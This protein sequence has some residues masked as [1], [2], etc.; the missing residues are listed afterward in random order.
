M[1]PESH[2]SHWSRSD[3]HTRPGCRRSRPAACARTAGHK[4]RHIEGQC[5]RQ[6]MKCMGACTQGRG[7]LPIICAKQQTSPKTTILINT[8]H[9]THNIQV[10]LHTHTNTQVPGGTTCRRARCL[11]RCPCC[12]R[13]PRRSWR[14]RRRRRWHLCGG[15]LPS[16]GRPRA[17]RASPLLRPAAGRVLVIT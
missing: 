12:A 7:G 15:S 16:G 14:A 6:A 4:R 9:S 3:R 5:G 10:L 1:S 8:Q 13:C 2:T 17:E 11:R